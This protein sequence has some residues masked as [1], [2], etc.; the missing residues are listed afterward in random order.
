M[1]MLMSLGIS[2]MSL[3]SIVMSGNIGG[4]W[5]VPAMHVSGD[6]QVGTIEQQSSPSPPQL[7]QLVPSQTRLVCV[8]VPAPP[9][10]PAFGVGG[11]AVGPKQHGPPM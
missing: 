6:K 2:D 4:I 9:V 1:L 11:G 5:Q 10:P 7:T 3:P 8:H